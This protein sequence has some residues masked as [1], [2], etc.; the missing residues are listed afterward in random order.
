MSLFSDDPPLSV[1]PAPP[2]KALTPQERRKRRTE[3]L[4]AARLR[5]AIRQGL[6]Q[7]GFITRAE[8]GAAVGVQEND[9]IRLLKRSV[10]RK[11]DVELLEAVALLLGL[12]PGKAG[13]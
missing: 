2:R 9:A 7:R 8:I 5:T 6:E 1:S 10:W 13:W 11:G 3:Q 12:H 4:K